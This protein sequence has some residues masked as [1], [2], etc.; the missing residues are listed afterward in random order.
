MLYRFF[1]NSVEYVSPSLAIA[2][3]G[4]GIGVVRICD[5]EYQLVFHRTVHAYEV[6]CV[7]WDSQND[8][9][10]YS[11]ILFAVTYFAFLTLLSVP[12][13]A[14]DSLLKVTDLRQQTEVAVVKGHEAGVTSIVSGNNHGFELLTGRFVIKSCWIVIIISFV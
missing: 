14:D 10:L 1:S 12:L 4:G 6:W 11:G 8:N 13:G 3:S 9:V 5:E 2:D 7:C